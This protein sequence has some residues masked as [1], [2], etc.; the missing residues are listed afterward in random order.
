MKKAIVCDIDGCL[1]EHLGEGSQELRNLNALPG[2]LEAFHQWALKDYKIILMSG[3][4][5][6][7]R[8]QTE[9]QLAKVGITYDV[10]ILGVGRGQRIL[11]NDMKPGSNEPTAAAFNLERNKGF[12]KELIE[13]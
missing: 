5:E 10:L 6:S 3:R 4:R 7:T 1:L 13:V 8:R 2:V 9:E 12:S 11:I